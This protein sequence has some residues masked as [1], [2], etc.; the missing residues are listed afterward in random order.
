MTEY[1]GEV[2]S[3]YTDAD[4]QADGVLINTGDYFVEANG[5]PVN[6]VTASVWHEVI[7]P[8]KGCASVTRTKETGDRFIALMDRLMATAKADRDW[9]ILDGG[10]FWLIPN[11]VNGYTLMYP[12]DY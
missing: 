7:D 4:A 12:S 5:R 1:F 3:T 11:E 10:R 2:I 9:L 8:E 6:R